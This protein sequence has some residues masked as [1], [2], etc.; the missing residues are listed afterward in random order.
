MNSTDILND[1]EKRI[2]NLKN[3]MKNDLTYFVIKAN[4]PGDNKN[5][6]PSRFLVEYFFN[7]IKNKV[8]IFRNE[9]FDSMD[10]PY[11]LLESNMDIINAKMIGCQLE[12]NELGRFIDI[13]VYKNSIKSIS[14][15]EINIEP[16]KCF[17]CG[18]NSAICVRLRKHSYVELMN[19]INN[20]VDKFLYFSLCDLIKDSMETELNLDPKFGLVTPKTNGSHKDMNYELM[21]DSIDTIAPFIA[22]MGLIGFRNN[23]EETYKEIRK[24]GVSCEKEMFYSSY[25]IN[26]YKGL[27]F[28]LGF[29]VA[30]FG[31]YL[32]DFNGTLS[33]RI[34]LLAEPLENDF[35]SFNGVTFGE[36]AYLDYQIKGVRGEILNGVFNAFN[37]LGYLD[38]LSDECLLNTL[39]KII[40]N[41]ED[42]VLLKRC[43]TIEK[44][45]EVKNMFKDKTYLDAP[46]LTEMAIKDNLSFGGSADILVVT[47]FLKKVKEIIKYE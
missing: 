13:D 44:Y 26:T 14:R 43:K 29:V 46:K 37:N 31:N 5:I 3:F 8:D 22:K 38:D 39:I 33:D 10:G 12:D 36:K 17:I 20:S 40:S 16:R 4:I 23:I 11:Y 32:Q 19:A 2:E 30:A 6:V 7:Q 24:I 47:I 28:A 42:T 18:E 1:R 25:G 34:K 41:L 27:I 35:N 45:N 15:S 21:L 9:F